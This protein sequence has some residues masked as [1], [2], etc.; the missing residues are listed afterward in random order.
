MD[1]MIEKEFVSSQ[2][3][4]VTSPSDSE[5]NFKSE[6]ENFS[7]KEEKTCPAK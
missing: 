6:C 4:N 2:L 7:R 1:V 5:T 3:Q